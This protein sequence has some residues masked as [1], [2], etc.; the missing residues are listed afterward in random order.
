MAF[1]FA[2]VDAAR[3]AVHVKN[4]GRAYRGATYEQVPPLSPAAVDPAVERLVTIGIGAPQR[5]PCD[6]VHERARWVG[7]RPGDGIGAGKRFRVRRREGGPDRVELQVV[8][9]HGYGG[10]GSPVLEFRDWREALVAVAAHEAR[11]VWQFEH[12][13][14]RSEVDAERYA[15]ERLAAFRRRGD[16]ARA[17]S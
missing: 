15:G 1:G 7:A 6:N 3:V 8:E 2:D 11:H 4:S 9:R 12:D 14:P 5:F 13:A 17:L 16:G 10:K